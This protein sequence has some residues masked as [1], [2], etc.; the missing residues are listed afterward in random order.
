MIEPLQYLAVLTSGLYGVLMARNKGMDPVGVVWVA[1]IVAFGGGTL[2]DVLLD[3]RP[4]FWIEHDHYTWSL[5]AVAVVGALLPRLPA[6]LD[7]WLLVPDALGLALFSIVGARIAMDAPG[8]SPFIA[9]LFGV[10]TGA[11]GGVI[12]DVVCNEVPRLFLPATPLY[13]T[14]ALAGCWVYIGLR[15]GGLGE[16][17]TLPAGV[18]AVTALRI[19][20]VRWHWTLPAPG[21]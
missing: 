1:F 16:E 15:Y 13:S 19:M 10:I 17:I 7:R 3:R 18:A 12:A 9:S 21:R 4:L 5:F 6:R 2:R 8:V 11:F 20:A 14:C